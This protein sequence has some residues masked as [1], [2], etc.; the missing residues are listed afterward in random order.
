[1]KRV[2]ILF[3]AFVS[4]I[5]FLNQIS[6]VAR[7][8][9]FKI[10]V[11][12]P[13]SG[14]LAKFGEENYIGLEFA[15]D[16]INE[17]GGVLGSKIT[18]VKGDANSTTAAVAEAE[19]LITQDKIKVIM[20]TYSSTLSAAASEVAE[21][22]RVIYWEIIGVG[23]A[24]TD[25]GFQYYFRL[26]S[27]GSELGTGAVEYLVEEAAPKIKVK[28]K[29]LKVAVIYEDGLFGKTCGPAAK[30]KL[31]EIGI[32]PVLVESY[33]A[34]SLDLSSLI[35]K[36]KALTPDA[37][38]ATSYLTD[39]I[40]FQRQSKELGLN[41]KVF[42]GTGG[43]Y[44]MNELADALGNEANYIIDVDPL[45]VFVPMILD[46]KQK[47]LQEFKKKFMAKYGKYNPS[48]QTT[49]A[50]LAAMAFFEYV[51]PKA[52]SFDPEAIRKAA[53]EI[54]IAKGTLLPGFGFKFAAPGHPSAGHNLKATVG[55]AQWQKK[56]LIPI[57][58]KDLALTD[59]KLPM[60]TFG[61]RTM[62]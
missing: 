11:L 38:I 56:R 23:D 61:Q 57:F 34:K 29:D 6:N 42:I 55:I 49:T 12:Y 37:V 39:A 2:F 46:P 18:Y 50:Y 33:S 7:A 48:P 26:N 4:G 59:V 41:V 28:A 25:R 20:G 54:D 53:L 24:L 27:K 44:D 47:A 15:R 3:M 35:L 30:K 31:E 14:T 21:R 52:G 22:N 36:I 9:D 60:P 58:P 5:A 43:G 32:I 40:L 51:L 13:F 17:R 1:M 45:G 19:R 62:E 10:G 8:A 16:I